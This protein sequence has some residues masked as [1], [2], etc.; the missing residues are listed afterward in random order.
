M[1]ITRYTK[2]A[3]TGGII[4]LLIILLGTLLL[5]ELSGYE[6]KVLIKKSLSGINTLCNTIALASATILALLLTVLSISSNSKS[7]LKKDHYLQVL[8]IAK[9]DTVVFIASVISFILLNL[10]ITE[11]DTV[12]TNWFNYIYYTS[13]AISSILTSGLIV[14]VLMLYSTIV[15]IIKIIGLEMYDHPL[16]E[17]DED[18]DEDEN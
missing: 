5:G 12:P 7:K 13:L 4:S 3:I 15:N 6:A 18:E 9:L 16:A 1:K 10:P 17:V 14:V 2:R 11:S 8:Q